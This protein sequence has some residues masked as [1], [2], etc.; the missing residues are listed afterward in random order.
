MARL[1]FECGEPAVNDHH[2]VP[3][4]RG[5]TRT[6]PLCDKCHTLIHE[7]GVLTSILSREA[8]AKKKA[9]GERL[10]RAPFGWKA[11]LNTG[12]LVEVPKQQDAIRRAKELHAQKK[13]IRDI[14]K[15]VNTELGQKMSA[16]T[17]S[18]IFTGKHFSVEGNERVFTPKSKVPRVKATYALD[19]VALAEARAFLQ[20]L[21]KPARVRV[22]R[23]LADEFLTDKPPAP[24]PRP[25]L[26]PEEPENEP[27]PDEPEPDEGVLTGEDL[28][29]MFDSSSV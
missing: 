27:E 26:K 12:L 28:T 16:G 17:L 24:K 7:K 4:S 11:D 14:I 6:L 23:F 18:R 21:P 20:G 3:A 15:T 5:G 22:V 9:R 25:V 8:L 19:I 13:S 10:G 2:V 29:C 1:C